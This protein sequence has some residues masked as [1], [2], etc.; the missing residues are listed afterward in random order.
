MHLE[1]VVSSRISR[2]LLNEGLAGGVR[3][4]PVPVFIL[5][6]EVRPYALFFSRDWRKPVNFDFMS[7]KNPASFRIESM[8][9]GE[10]G[11]LAQA[12][13]KAFTRD[14]RVDPLRVSLRML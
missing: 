3:N 12:D 7:S 11:I 13:K 8:R 10:W 5:R 1:L 6:V 14:S 4:Y 9:S 2:K